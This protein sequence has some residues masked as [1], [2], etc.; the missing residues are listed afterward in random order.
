[1]HV[2]IFVIGGKFCAPCFNIHHCH[3]AVMNKEKNISN[4]SQWTTLF[5]KGTSI[6]I[7]NDIPALDPHYNLYTANNEFQRKLKCAKMSKG[8]PR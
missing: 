8:D 3:H 1:M 4:L 2:F 5:V 6:Q 7:Q